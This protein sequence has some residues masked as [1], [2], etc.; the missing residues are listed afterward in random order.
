[1]LIVSASAGADLPG[2]VE[3]TLGLAHRA[4]DGLTA[5]G[6]GPTT[7]P[8]ND[9]GRVRATVVDVLMEDASSWLLVDIVDGPC[10]VSPGSSSR[11]RD[12]ASTVTEYRRRHTS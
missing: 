10:K 6:L 1:M 4:G 11:W 7:E 2:G 5:I 9:E 8:P 12:P 3:A